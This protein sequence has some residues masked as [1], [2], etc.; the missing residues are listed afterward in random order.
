MDRRK[1]E[2]Y[3]LKDEPCSYQ[4]AEACFFRPWG[5]EPEADGCHK[6]GYEIDIADTM[7][8]HVEGLV[9]DADRES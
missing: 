5:V 8:L 9:E 6:G 3:G 1:S 4:A 7:G 2:R